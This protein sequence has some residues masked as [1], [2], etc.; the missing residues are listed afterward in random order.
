ME[1]LLKAG[2]VLFII[3][4]IMARVC[5]MLEIEVSERIKTLVVIPIIIGFFVLVAWLAI[6]IIT[7]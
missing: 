5:V 4:L 3:P 7:F 6:Y 2:L 1:Y